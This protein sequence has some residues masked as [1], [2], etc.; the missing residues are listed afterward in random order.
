M[1]SS[2]RNHDQGL[3]DNNIASIEP[4]SNFTEEMEQIVRD[5]ALQLESALQQYRIEGEVV[6]IDQCCIWQVVLFQ[7]YG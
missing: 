3:S 7:V 5:Q 4:E 6:G 2:R 1:R